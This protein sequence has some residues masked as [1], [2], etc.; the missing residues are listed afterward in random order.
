MSYETYD[1]KKRR[2]WNNKQNY[3]V[4]KTCTTCKY[5]KDE[6]FGSAMKEKWYKICYQ[7]DYHAL[8]KEDTVCKSYKKKEVV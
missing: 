2:F 8:V 4:A 3:R 1:Q 7:D 6:F 5:S